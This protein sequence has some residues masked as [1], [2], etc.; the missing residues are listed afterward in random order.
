MTDHHKPRAGKTLEQR[1]WTLLR[2]RANEHWNGPKLARELG[3]TWEQT[4]EAVR[5]LRAKGCVVAKGRTSG[6]AYHATET[7][8]E[9]L[10]GSAPGS[11][12]AIV[13]SAKARSAKRR[14]RHTR[15]RRLRSECTLAEVWR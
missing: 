12:A 4:R 7:R 5:R 3:T 10:R 14:T 8:P 9:D 6:I 11:V 13:A 15:P 1:V 2:R